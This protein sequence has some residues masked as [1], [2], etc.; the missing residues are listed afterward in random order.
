M[1]YYLGI[2]TGGTFTDAVLTDQVTRAVVARAKSLT[3]RFDLSMGIADAIAQLP[4]QLLQEVALVALSTTLTTNSVVESRGSPVCV[5]LVGYNE[6]QIANS[7]LQD[8]VGSKAIVS[9]AGGH[10]AMGIELRPLDLAAA[11]TAI[12]A[13]KGKVTAFALSAS[14]AVRNPAHE[15]E[16]KLLVQRLCDVPVTCGHELASSLGAPR[17]ALTVAMNARMIS[18]VKDLVRAVQATLRANAILAPLMIVKG[19]GSLINVAGALSQPVTT[20]LSGPAASVLGACALANIQDGIIADMGGTTTDIAVVR[21][22]LPTLSFDGALIGQWRP[23][24]ESIRVHAIGLGGDSELGYKGGDGFAIG[25][26]RVVPLSL[27]VHQYPQFLAVLERQ[28]TETPHASQLR[29]VQRLRADEAVLQDLG[30][31]EIRAWDILGQ[32]PVDLEWANQFDRPLSRGIARLE[33]KGLAIYSGFTPTDAAHVLGASTH[34]S[35]PAAVAGARIWA[36][37]M[38][39]LY[40]MG[41]WPNG[42]EIGP[43]QFALDKLV[44]AICQKLIETGLNEFGHLHES[45]AYKTAAL[46]TQIALFKTARFA[47][48][49]PSQDATHGAAGLLPQT[50]DSPPEADLFR[51]QF[52]PNLPLV[53]VGA[54]AA[55][56]YPNVA[57]SFGMQLK[58]PPNADVAN[59]YGAVLGKVSQR[60]HVTLT[61]PQRGVFR[62][63]LPSGPENFENLSLALEAARSNAASRAHAQALLAGAQSAT[64]AFETQENAVQN[65]IDGNLFFEARVTAIAS[66][67]PQTLA[68]VGADRLTPL[69]VT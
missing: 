29:F 20:V 64:V 9:L 26:R 51:L 19:D 40:G 25:P 36:R 4:P 67:P 47:A 6:A 46:M 42:D 34:W 10:D 18:H 12:L 8:L 69:A 39:H 24:V 44:E 41:K 27:L 1:L 28:C 45:A 37:Q 59:A 7:G 35:R 32:N 16:L 60:V 14:F 53:A 38:R 58:L 33:R 48:P 49:G 21:N 22:G 61:Q 13:Q 65:D 57:R 54:P 31:D 68:T 55:S 3:T 5:M 30:D 62:V 43:S 50:N 17:R 56:I 23:M 52:S 15:M 2:D 63:Y 11:E 66:G